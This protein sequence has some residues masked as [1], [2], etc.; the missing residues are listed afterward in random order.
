MQTSIFYIALAALLT[1]N[2][3]L[4]LTIYT[5]V[6]KLWPTP[7]KGSWQKYVFWPLF[8]GGLGLTLLFSALNFKP[9]LDPNWELLIVGVPLMLI[10][11]AV[12]VS[13]L[14]SRIH[15]ARIRGW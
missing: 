9:H 2:L 12:T 4:L 11:L 3:L 1:L 8:R 14:G 6:I 10:G 7:G 13:I 15:M 5:T